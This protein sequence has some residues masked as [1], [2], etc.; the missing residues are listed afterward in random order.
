[1]LFPTADLRGNKK[2]KK[3]KK[4]KEKK[5]EKK[6]IYRVPWSRAA[7]LVRRLSFKLAN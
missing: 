6:E 4:M 5:M 3:M 2:T 1:M 7:A